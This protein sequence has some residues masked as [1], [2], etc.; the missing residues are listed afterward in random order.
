MRIDPETGDTDFVVMLPV[1]YPTSATIGGPNLD[2]LHITTRGPD[3]GGI[4][5]VT[6]PMGIRGVPE[7]EADL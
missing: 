1:K 2:T 6:L 5:A 3:G 4:F 7:P